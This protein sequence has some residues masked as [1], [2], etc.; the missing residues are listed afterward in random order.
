MGRCRRVTAPHARPRKVHGE[1]YRARR[2]PGMPL[3]VLGRREFE[4][5]R[6]AKSVMLDWYA[7]FYNHDRRH[8]A[9]AMMTP[10]NYEK[11]A[12]TDRE[13]A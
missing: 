5:S 1:F 4:N 3:T 6:Q 11:V 9:S 12:A 2:S 13:A 10:A 8:S 7:G